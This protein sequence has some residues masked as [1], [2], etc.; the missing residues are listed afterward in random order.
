MLLTCYTNSQAETSDTIWTHPI[1]GNVISVKF[2]PDG[3]Y[4]YSGSTSNIV[5]KIDVV[6]NKV[7]K[8]FDAP[9]NLHSMDLSQDGKFLLLSGD[10][11]LVIVNAESGEIF[12]TFVYPFYLAPDKDDY[13]TIHIK[14]VSFSYDGKYC[15]IV[16]NGGNPQTK[17]NHSNL[18]VW[19]LETGKVVLNRKD[20][21]LIFESLLFSPTENILAV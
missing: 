21:N 18:I 10:T 8:A 16:Y 1:A 9:K 7:L 17:T 15:G 14:S 5:T 20:G 4:V 19:E 13:I 2:S 12:K 3:N 6:T 11:A